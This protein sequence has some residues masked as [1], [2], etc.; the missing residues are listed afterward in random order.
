MII[1][2]Q[3]HFRTL[4]PLMYSPGSFKRKNVEQAEKLVIWSSGTP[5]T[6][7]SVARGVPQ[8]CFTY[9]SS[10]SSTRGTTPGGENGNCNAAS[11]GRWN[12]YLPRFIVAA[13]RSKARCSR[14]SWAVF[15]NK[16]SCDR[17][18]AGRH[19]CR[20]TL[21]ELQSSRVTCT[22]LPTNPFQNLLIPEHIF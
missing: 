19:I 12:F 14:N 21:W 3:A 8:F 18:Y 6:S 7:R 16:D 5:E 10:T 13:P 17:I 9:D 22:L 2:R 20:H 15:R 11:L 1:T 4:H